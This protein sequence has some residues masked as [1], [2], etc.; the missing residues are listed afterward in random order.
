MPRTI[1][2]N[3]H[4]PKSVYRALA[5]DAYVGGGDI[6]ITRLIAP[7]RIVAL[8]KH[9]ED[10]IVEDAS[11]R[12][13][14]LLGQAVHGVLE[15]AAPEDAVVEKRL[16]MVIEGLPGVG[17]EL[18][19]QP[20]LFED[21][22]LYDYKVTS[23][24]SFMFGDKPEWTA[25]LN[26]QAMLHRHHGDTVKA[27]N[28][29]A[30]LRDWQQRKAKL[31]KD[32]PQSNIHVISIPL[33]TPD[34][35]WQYAKQ[36]MALHQK[37]WNEFEAGEFNANSLPLCTDDER[38]YRGGKFAVIKEGNKKADKLFDT[39]AEAEEYRTINGPALK[40]KKFAPVQARPGENIRCESYCD[41]APF[42]PFF[43]KLAAA[44][45]AHIED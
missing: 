17:W 9:N 37:T 12:V 18:S 27:V 19:G 31:E 5:A 10:Q 1:T 2:N 24:W 8:R 39:E 23:V 40:G 41:C 45:A 13:W 15:R 30:I 29:V 6:S 14:S 32:Y 44:K 38:W 36:R 26:L 7:P 42:C 11:D 28:I 35:V 34:Q 21:N 25:Q 20:D 33:W 22:V 16:S 4:L 3:F 43:Q